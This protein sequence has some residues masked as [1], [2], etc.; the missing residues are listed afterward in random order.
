[1]KLTRG[2]NTIPI[3]WIECYKLG[4][5]PHISMK[6]LGPFADKNSLWFYINKFNPF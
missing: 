5:H 1:M 6:I 2:R 3:T 4:Y